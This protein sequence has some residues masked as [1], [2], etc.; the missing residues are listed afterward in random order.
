MS[1]LPPSPSGAA[2]PQ[3]KLL[4]SWKEC[5]VRGLAQADHR[6]LEPP[7]PFQVSQP[8]F[9]HLQSGVDNCASLCKGACV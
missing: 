1:P 3:E 4:E 6:H 8:Q 7:G 2:W 9:L 5:S